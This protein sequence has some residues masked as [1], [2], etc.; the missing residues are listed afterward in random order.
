[1]QQRKVTIGKTNEKFVEIREGLE[2]GDRVV[3][4]PMSLVDEGPDDGQEISPEG[5][6]DEAVEYG[7]V[8][9]AQQ[10]DQLPGKK[11][12]AKKQDSK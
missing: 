1:M 2:E 3:L 8:D 7:D 6:S 9:D 12:A 10:A 11:S 5:D 4:N